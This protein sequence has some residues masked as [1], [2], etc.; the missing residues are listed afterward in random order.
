MASKKTHITRGCA[1][2]MAEMAGVPEDQIRRMGHWAQESMEKH[3]L[4]CLPRKAM[5]ALSGRLNIFLSSQH[6]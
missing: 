5:R 1:T 4:S 6:D 3:Y 2:R